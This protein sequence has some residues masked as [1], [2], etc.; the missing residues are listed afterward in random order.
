MC[1]IFGA[2]VDFDE[3]D[4]AGTWVRCE[5]TKAARKTANTPKKMQSKRLFQHK[6]R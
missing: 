2:S 5:R 4:D 1:L 3:D 6:T